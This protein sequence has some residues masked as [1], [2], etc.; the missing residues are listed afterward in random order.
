MI[1]VIDYGAGNLFSV[2]NALSFLGVEYMVTADKTQ[3]KAADKLILPGVGAF[4]KAVSALKE[5]ELFDLIKDQAK[6]KYLL[7]I[8]LG[9][10]LLFEKSEEFGQTEGLGLIDG[11]VRK[12]TPGGLPV[13]HMGW[14]RLERK[15]S[16]PV[17]QDADGKYVYFVHSYAACTASENIVFD[18]DYGQRIPALVCKNNVFGA[19]FH[20]EKSGHEGLSILKSFC[21][22]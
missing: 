9:M 11:E 16:C 19:Q 1:A 12:I 15:N 4:A 14:N 22:L 10:Q 13:P 17:G 18:C 5:R 2:Q 20:P 7:G 6:E 8:C 21:M 3:I